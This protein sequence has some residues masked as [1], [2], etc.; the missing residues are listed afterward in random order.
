MVIVV[1]MSVDGGG[2][3]CVASCCCSMEEIVVVS[4]VV[5]WLLCQWMVADV[6]VLGYLVLV[7]CIPSNISCCSAVGASAPEHVGCSE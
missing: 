2:G 6:V 5:V 1:V 3:G 4:V 7:G